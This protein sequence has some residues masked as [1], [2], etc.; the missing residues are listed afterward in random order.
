MAFE[1][2]IFDLDGTL[3]DTLDDLADSGNEML[4]SE[5]FPTHP[6]DAYRIFVG[7]GVRS[8]MERILPG[9]AQTEATIERCMGV[10]RAVYQRRWKAKTKPYAG[11]PELLDGLVER[12]IRL[13]VLSNKPHD[14]TEQCIQEFVGDWPWEMVFGMRDGVP[15]KP[16]PAGAVQILESLE[17]APENCLYLGDTDTDMK[18]AK[19]ANLFAVG[20]LWGFRPKEELEEHGADLLLAEPGEMLGF[21]DS[22]LQS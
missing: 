8:L 20:V 22:Q 16:D 4:E 10:Y 9:E 13:T 5:G 2:A 6:V 17:V 3:L 11:V 7:D 21:L 15:K 1:A 19:A 12:G 14:F 18:T